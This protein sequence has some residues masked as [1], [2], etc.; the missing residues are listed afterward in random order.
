VDEDI[1]HTLVHYLFTGAYQTLKSQGVSGPPDSTTEYRRGILVYCTARLHGLDSL[2]D[3]AMRY[4]SLFGRELSVFQILDIASDIF[5]K[6][7]VDEIW[8]PDHLKTMIEAAFKADETMFSRER[9]LN[10][11][12]ATAFTKAL[13]KIMVGTYTNRIASM[14]KKEGGT[15]EGI[16]GNSTYHEAPVVKKSPTPALREEPGPHEGLTT[17]SS[18]VSSAG[19]NSADDGDGKGGDDWIGC[20]LGSEDQAPPRMDESSAGFGFGRWG[21]GGASGDSKDI[22]DFKKDEEDDDNLLPSWCTARIGT[23]TKKGKK[24]KKGNKGK[25]PTKFGIEEV[26]DTLPDAKS[27]EDTW[28]GWSF[29]KKKKEDEKKP[30]TKSLDTCGSTTTTK[31]DKKKSSWADLVEED[32]EEEEPNPLPAVEEGWGS[33]STAKTK[34][35]KDKAVIEE[36]TPKPASKD[37]APAKDDTWD[38]ASKDG[39]GKRDAKKD[40]NDWGDFTSTSKD[41]K[42][43]DDTD[44]KAAA[45]RSPPLSILKGLPVLAGGKIKNLLGEVVGEL[46]EEDMVHAKKCFRMIYLCD[47]EG[48]IKNSKDKLIAKAKTICSQNE[49]EPEPE[50]PAEE[51]EPAKPVTPDI[52]VLDGLKVEADGKILDLDGNAIGEL[53][54]GDAK[55][56]AKKKFTCNEMGEFRNKKWNVVGLARVLPVAQEETAKEEPEA[57]RL[58]CPLRARHI[59]EGSWKNCDKC[60]AMI[61][62][63]SI[64]LAQEV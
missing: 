59:L 5:P 48:N 14:T 19:G 40:D 9:F 63:L 52:S 31:P 1:G 33:F 56:I 8:F 35:K 17:P 24:G 61:R 36:V 60:R 29:D 6:L 53:I 42:S 27:N 3:H 16:F 23:T 47:E 15:R 57:E 43:K 51:A 4:I 2:A 49:T 54:D 12:G 25:K 34:K 13:V 41:K 58:V 39:K 7:L 44:A 46:M 38:W 64:Q 20:S 10:H 11:I 62:Q 30:A 28:G 22:G 37:I 45:G 18:S 55:V 50:V 21:F 26:D 32:E